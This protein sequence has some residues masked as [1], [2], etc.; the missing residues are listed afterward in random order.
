MGGFEISVYLNGELVEFGQARIYVEKA[1]T[2]ER[3]DGK[4]GYELR[5]AASA[6][7]THLLFTLVAGEKGREPTFAMKWL[8]EAKEPPETAGLNFKAYSIKTYPKNEKYAG[9]AASTHYVAT[10]NGETCYIFITITNVN[11]EKKWVNGV[12]NGV[13]VDQVGDHWMR[14]EVREGRFGAHYEMPAGTAE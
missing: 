13:Y 4:T 3:E 8:A 12:F 7:Y 9:V 2:F 5:D 6:D 11:T 10:L 1:I 14:M